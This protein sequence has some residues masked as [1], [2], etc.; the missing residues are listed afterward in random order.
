MHDKIFCHHWSSVKWKDVMALLYHIPVNGLPSPVLLKHFSENI[1]KHLWVCHTTIEVEVLRNDFF[2]AA[3]IPGCSSFPYSQQLCKE[4]NKELP[5]ISLITA[6]P[7]RV[8]LRTS[9]ASSAFPTLI[10]L[11]LNS[12]FVP[13][14][15][16]S[17]FE[18]QINM[19]LKMTPFLS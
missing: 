13:P 7:H 12:P 5:R 16:P 19:I 6:E 9:R 4:S 2:A 1:R 8:V 11:L 10:G 17:G 3:H 18:V 14:L 15:L